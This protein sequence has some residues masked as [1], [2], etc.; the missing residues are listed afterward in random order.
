MP[1]STRTWNRL[2]ESNRRRERTKTRTGERRSSRGEYA[3][4]SEVDDA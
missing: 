4:F 3:A 2:T 1:R